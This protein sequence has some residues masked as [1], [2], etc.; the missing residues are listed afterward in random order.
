MTVGRRANRLEI[1]LRGRLTAQAIRTARDETVAAL[2]QLDPGFDVI[3][4]LSAF[5]PPSPEDAEPIVDAQQRLVD[6]DVGRVVRVS[7]DSTSQV[8]VNAFE[9]RSRRAGYSGETAD[10]VDAARR[11]LGA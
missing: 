6:A 9:R 8:V 7:D 4:D 10:S 1:T 3:T 2:D 5:A 11:Q